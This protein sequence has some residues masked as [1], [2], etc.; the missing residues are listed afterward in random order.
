[1]IIRDKPIYFRKNI[2]MD[3][4]MDNPSKLEVPYFRIDLGISLMRT[5]RDAAMPVR[6]QPWL[7]GHVSSQWLQ[8][9]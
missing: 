9:Q 6:N 7:G 1:M 2:P 8:E 5:S 3:N 4:P